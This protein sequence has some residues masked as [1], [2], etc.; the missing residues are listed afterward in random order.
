MSM[1]KQD[2]SGDQAHSKATFI[3][4]IQHRQNAT[5]QGQITWKDRDETRKFR[6]ELE[7]IKLIDSAAEHNKMEAD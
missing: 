4:Q 6:S 2:G 3:V 1:S 5:W 7:L